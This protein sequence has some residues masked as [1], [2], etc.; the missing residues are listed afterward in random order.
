MSVMP[1]SPLSNQALVLAYAL[2][3]LHTLQRPPSP[4]LTD[5]QPTIGKPLTRPS[6]AS[7][8]RAAW[9]GQ[10]LSFCILPSRCYKPLFPEV[11]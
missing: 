10:V 9:H 6:P 8:E 5:I 2:P 4:R 11:K 1:E 3:L 7:F